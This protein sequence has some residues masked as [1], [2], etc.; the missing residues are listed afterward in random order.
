MSL[1][2][3]IVSEQE[4]KQRR[5]VGSWVIPWFAALMILAVGVRVVD[6]TGW[7]GSDDSS[8][9]SAADYILAGETIQREHHQYGRM[10]VILPVVLSILVFGENAAAVALPMI[11][12]STLCVALV[13]I[14]GRLVW[15]WWEGLCAGTIVAVLPFFRVL[16][17]TAYPDVHACLW[18][19]AA[20]VLAVAGTRTLRSRRMVA[21]SVASGLALGLAVSAKVLSLPVCVGVFYLIGTHGRGTRQRTL[22][23]VAVV[24]G[25]L[26]YVMADGLFYLWAANDFW[27]KP[28]ALLNVQADESL[29]SR[30]GFYTFVN[31]AWDRLTMLFHPTASGWGLIALAFWPAALIVLSVN[32][33][34]RGIAAWAVASYLLIAYVPV[35]FKNGP[36]PLPIFH[37]RHVLVACIPFALCLA[38][39]ARS[40]GDR[41]LSGRLVRHGWPI[42][43]GSVVALAYV[44]PRELS[45]FRDR[46]TSRVGQAIEQ[47]IATTTWN[48]E[49][50]IF[51]PASLYL[52]YR[53]LF[54]PR[55]RARLRVAVDDGSP[56][57]W[58]D[59][60]VGI[61]SRHKPLPPPEDA[62][63]L[64]TPTQLRGETEF[65]DYGVG[66]PQDDLDA[67]RLA[68]MITTI[69]R[70]QDKSIGV[71]T[72]RREDGEALLVLLGRDPTVTRKLARDST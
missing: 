68:P 43:F 56:P 39:L 71:L 37:G 20:M 5:R 67:W 62:Y 35:S 38:W 12:A 63:L 58:R 19:T 9:F 54:P 11:I 36:H 18:A 66:L 60:A 25:G 50:E 6:P 64:A 69:G 72:D 33:S 65:W 41:L 55:L 21:Y 1:G 46:P 53:I 27:F 45:G 42:V 17:T 40:T 7:L 57:W 51:M 52:R 26:T 15:G 14:L 23:S 47:V 34:G 32:R 28:H 61:R 3:Q 22:A 16:S 8:Y 4:R 70:F 44:N 2:A 24:L 13:V 31:L 10:S 59:A 49:R 29:F 30:L 48:D